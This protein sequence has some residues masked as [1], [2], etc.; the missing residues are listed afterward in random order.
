MMKVALIATVMAI[1]QQNQVNFRFPASLPFVREASGLPRRR[2][3]D[4]DWRRHTS[5]STSLLGSTTVAIMCPP[6]VF[7]LPLFTSSFQHKQLGQDI[8]PLIAIVQVSNSE[9]SLFGDLDGCPGVSIKPSPTYMGPK[10]S[11]RSPSSKPW[12]KSQ[13]LGG[14]LSGYLGWRSLASLPPPSVSSPLHRLAST[15]DG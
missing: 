10:S 13:L 8:F 1:V 6:P 15:C 12:S 5:S 3:G 9:N 4:L 7:C 14:E 2:R 11:T